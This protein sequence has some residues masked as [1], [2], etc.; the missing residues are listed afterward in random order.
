MFTIRDSIG[1]S[2]KQILRIQVFSLRVFFVNI[3]LVN[4]ESS[5]MAHAPAGQVFQAVFLLLIVSG[6]SLIFL[7]SSYFF[8]MFI[9]IF[10]YWYYLK[11]IFACYINTFP[12]RDFVEFIIGIDVINTLPTQDIVGFIIGIDVMEMVRQ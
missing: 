7:G 8:L 9:D 10:T 3:Y 5:T 2:I 4:S 6:S 12:T 11:F 1:L